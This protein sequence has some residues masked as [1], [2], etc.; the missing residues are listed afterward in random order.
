MLTFDKTVTLGGGISALITDWSSGKGNG[1]ASPLG[2]RASEQVKLV[3]M[4]LTT[5]SVSSN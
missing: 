2:G 4:L 1:C 5:H 3:S